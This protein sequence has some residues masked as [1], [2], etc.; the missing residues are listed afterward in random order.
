MLFESIKKTNLI[1]KKSELGSTWTGAYP[2]L[3]NFYTTKRFEMKWKN[4]NKISN[5][6]TKNI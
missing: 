1:I 4:L 5:N 3:S 2:N 6:I